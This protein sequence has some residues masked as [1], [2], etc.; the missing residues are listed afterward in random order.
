MNEAISAGDLVWIPSAVKL[1]SQYAKSLITKIP[2]N[3]LVTQV[4]NNHINVLI[5]GEE[6]TVNKLDAY[7]PAKSSHDT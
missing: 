6:W 2:R 3:F 5:D 7:P 4:G 1:H